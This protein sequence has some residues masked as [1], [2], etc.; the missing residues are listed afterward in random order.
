M[1]LIIDIDE[2]SYRECKFRKD[3]LSLGGEPT[4][5][6]FNMRMETTISKGIPLSEELEKIKNEL[7]SKVN[8]SNIFG[9][10]YVDVKDIN[11]L[12][13]SRIEELKGE[14]EC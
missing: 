4:D 11:K 12:F 5:L 1:K 9:S 13:D 10:A 6:T 14:Q 7:L 8:G 3:L 2:D